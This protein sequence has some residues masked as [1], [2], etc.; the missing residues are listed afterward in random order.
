MFKSLRLAAKTKSSARVKKGFP[1]AKIIQEK[2]FS[3]RVPTMHLSWNK[4][5]ENRHRKNQDQ[6]EA[7]HRLAINMHDYRQRCGVSWHVNA[8]QIRSEAAE[9]EKTQNMSNNDDLGH[10][11]PIASANRRVMNARK[12]AKPCCYPIWKTDMKE[13]LHLLFNKTIKR[14]WTDSL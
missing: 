5:W 6:Q 13:T 7:V 2:M 11:L 14:R 1:F 3:S 9:L 12:N 10:L 4:T 8:A